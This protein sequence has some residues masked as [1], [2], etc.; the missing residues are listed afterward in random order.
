MQEARALKA[1]EHPNVTRRMTTGRTSDG[2]LFVV[3]EPVE[4][5]SLSATLWSQGSLQPQD[6]VR[7]AIRLCAALEYLHQSGVVHGGARPADQ[8][9]RRGV[10]AHTPK[11]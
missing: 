4:G 5:E 6:V 2:R 1:L 11:P 8:H 9:F 7:L 10:A 3:T